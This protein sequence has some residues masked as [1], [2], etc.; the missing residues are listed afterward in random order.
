[1]HSRESPGGAHLPLARYPDV[2]INEALASE[3]SSPTAVLIA[4]CALS[5]SSNS[6]LA[7][8]WSFAREGRVRTLRLKLRE[9]GLHVN[10]SIDEQRDD[11]SVR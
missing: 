7:R 1:M 10:R 3:Y 4:L 11:C 5:G 6:D 8:L 9:V 2:A